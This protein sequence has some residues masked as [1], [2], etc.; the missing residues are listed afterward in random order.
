[1][2]YGSVSSITRIHGSSTLCKFSSTRKPG[3]ILF[4]LMGVLKVARSYLSFPNP[5]L[6]KL[7]SNLSLGQLSCRQLLTTAPIPPKTA[8]LRLWWAH[9][10]KRL[11]QSVFPTPIPATLFH[12]FHVWFFLANFSSSLPPS[13]SFFSLFLPPSL[14]PFYLLPFRL[15]QDA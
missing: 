7:F 1:M 3:P 11:F 5:Q 13:L 4:L 12:K 2:I 10:A 15:C 9:T 8:I 14:L 6:L